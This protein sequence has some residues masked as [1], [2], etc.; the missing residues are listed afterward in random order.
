MFNAF[1]FHCHLF[2]LN[3]YL[4]HIQTINFRL[5][6]YCNLDIL[7]HEIIKIFQYK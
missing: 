4:I 7:Y 6:F 5:S 1:I 3:I 2:F